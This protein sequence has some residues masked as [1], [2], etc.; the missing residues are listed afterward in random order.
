MLLVSFL[1]LLVGIPQ[2]FGDVTGDSAVVLAAAGVAAITGTAWEG[3]SSRGLDNLTI[4]LSVAFV[5]S[6]YL[7]PGLADSQLFTAGAILAIVIAVG[8]WKMRALAPSGAVATFLLALALYGTGGWKWTIPIFTFFILSSILSRVGKQR[9]ESVEGMFEKD[10]IRDYGQVFANGGVAGILALLNFVL[11]SFD[12]Y[13]F[14]LGSIAAVTADTWGTEIGLSSKRAP[15]LVTTWKQVEPGTNGGITMPGLLAGFAGSAVIGISASPWMG[16]AGTLIP[17]IILAGVGGGIVDSLF[18]ATVQGE[19]R[20]PV[21][22][23]TT[24]RRSHCN[25]Q[26]TH[27]Q[28]GIER[29]TNDVVNWTCAVAGAFFVLCLLGLSDVLGLT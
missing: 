14:Y 11:P 18:G 20:C 10:S 6:S 2:Y 27:H 22:G 4:P 24:E 26:P 8:A 23:K 25:N 3:L 9:K 19:Y 17:V 29:I 1:V 28:K 5:L 12:L 15:I 7:I 13:P 21:C 16:N